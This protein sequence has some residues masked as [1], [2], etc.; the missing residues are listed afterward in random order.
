MSQTET[1]PQAR[2]TE[3]DTRHPVTPAAGAPPARARSR[4]RRPLLIAGPL[5]AVVGGFAMYFLGGRYVSEENSYV[6]AATIS[7]AAQVSGQVSL[8]PVAQ[9]E[10][11]DLNQTLFQIDPE[12]Y[13]LAVEGARAQL[14]ITHDQ[15]A[16]QIENYKALQQQTVQAQ[17]NLTYAQ[18]Q[19]QRAQDLVNRGAGTQATLDAAQKEEQS[20]AAALAS[21]Q[22][23][24][25]ATLAQIG[26][27]GDL[28][29]ERRP[30]YLS[31]KAALDTAERN[32]RLTTVTAP[33]PGIV[34]NVNTIDV[35]SFLP[36]GQQA[37][38]MVSDTRVWVDTNL[39]E[40][41]LTYVRPNNPAT[42]EVDAYPGITFSGHVD[43]INPAS[44]SVFSLLPAQNATGNWVKVVQRIPVR[45]RIDPKP[46]APR[47]IN[48]M[49]ATVTID[50][51]HRR[52]LATLWRDLRSMFW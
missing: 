10:K 25:R 38:S 41:D 7:V 2:R 44:G 20:A 17:A 45:V 49:S 47:L 31:A 15:I 16:S 33:W 14:G 51:G 42:V 23:Q 19:R 13:R 8:V 6:G 9:N 21:T 34:T 48:G 28:P 4:W 11:V 24:A 27:D 3:Q 5:I 1:R 40:T 22:A 37:M 18:Q 30:Q 26:G 46:D 12:P 32:L 50:T 52:T 43:S 36:A 35:G 39:R 29:I